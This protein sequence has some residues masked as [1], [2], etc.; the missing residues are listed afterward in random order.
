MDNFSVLISP[1][2]NEIASGGNIMTFLS[3]FELSDICSGRN[4][5]KWSAL[6]EL[7]CTCTVVIQKQEVKQPYPVWFRLPAPFGWVQINFKNKGKTAQRCGKDSLRAGPWC[8]TTSPP[9]RPCRSG[10]RGRRWCPTTPAGNQQTQLSLLFI[11]NVTRLCL[12][13]QF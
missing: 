12:K 2:V 3:T 10:R 8:R 4:Y 1:Q 9:G 5:W 11:Q 13:A 7:R 6:Y